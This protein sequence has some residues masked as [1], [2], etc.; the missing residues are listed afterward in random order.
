MTGVGFNCWPAGATALDRNRVATRVKT[1]LLFL[2]AKLVSRYQMMAIVASCLIDVK[3]TILVKNCILTSVH[4]RTCLDWP[5][6]DKA[7]SIVKV[8][9]RGGNR[10]FSDLDSSTIGINYVTIGICCQRRPINLHLL[11]ILALNQLSLFIFLI[12]PSCWIILL[13]VYLSRIS[14]SLCLGLRSA[15]GLFLLVRVFTR[16]KTCASMNRLT[17]MHLIC[18][19]RPVTITDLGRSFD[20]FRLLLLFLLF[21]ILWSAE[22]ISCVLTSLEVSHLILLQLR[23]KV[24][25]NFLAVEIILLLARGHLTELLLAAQSSEFWSIEFS[26]LFEFKVVISSTL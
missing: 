24:T 4:C 19:I 18:G 16:F 26:I 6:A 10:T 20:L 23:I 15:E 12:S 8:S 17:H 7:H 22:A 25:V 9:H 13:Q 1:R 11:S 21:L 2:F 3:N 5:W 14:F